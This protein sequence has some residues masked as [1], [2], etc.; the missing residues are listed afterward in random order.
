MVN[1]KI[2]SYL[3]SIDVIIYKKKKKKIDMST[4]FLDSPRTFRELLLFFA[5]KK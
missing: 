4:N 2:L 1:I 3:P 5:K